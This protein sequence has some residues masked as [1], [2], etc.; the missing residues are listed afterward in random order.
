M[1]TWP[2]WIVT[3]L[4]L[5]IGAGFYCFPAKGCDPTLFRTMSI[6]TLVCMYLMWSLTYLAQLN[7][8]IAP[9]RSDLKAED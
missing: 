1:S 6:M 5:C 8:L 4:S 9:R 3:F 7:P 2:L